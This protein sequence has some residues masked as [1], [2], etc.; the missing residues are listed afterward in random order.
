MDDAVVP[1]GNVLLFAAVALAPTVAFWVLLRIPRTADWMGSLRRRGLKPAGPPIER[2]AADLRRVRRS[3]TALP[4]G[5]PAVRR[6]ATGQAYDA[7]L[8]QACDAVGI[9]HELDGVPSHGVERELERLRV[10]GA[11]RAAGLT[12]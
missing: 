5:A 2:L 11:L 10:E 4:P 6:N 12:I 9:G 7:L 8:G 3:M 1:F